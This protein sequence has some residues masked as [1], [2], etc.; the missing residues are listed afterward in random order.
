MIFPIPSWLHALAVIALVG[1]G[2]CALVIAGD[3]LAGRRQPM[4]IMNIVWPVTA[5]WAGPFALWGYFAIGRRS[6]HRAM[7]GAKRRG[8]TPPAERKPF[9]ASVALGSTHCGAGCTLGD[10]V[11]ESAV[12]LFPLTLAGRR[13]FGTWALD[14]ALA[15]AAQPNAT[16]AQAAR[17]ELAGKP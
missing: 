10:L 9:P 11:A 2:L 12:I 5:L 7:E 15:A 8:G 4:W 13:I 1:A 14:F 6:T 17:D 16:F 3:I